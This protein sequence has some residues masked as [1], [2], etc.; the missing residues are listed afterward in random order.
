MRTGPTTSRS[1]LDVPPAVPA[2]GCLRAGP[3]AWR[4]ALPA[5]LLAAVLAACT[6]S[7]AGSEASSDDS[8]GAGGP[9]AAEAAA[10][11][12]A[13]AAQDAAGAVPAGLAGTGLADDV[14]GRS[15]VSTA[16]L[17]VTVD[18]PAT[19]ADRVADLTRAAGGFVAAGSTGGGTG[20][21]QAHLTLRVPAE[22]LEQVLDEVAAL[23]RQVERSTTATDVTAEVADVDSRATSARA[24]LA[25]FRDRLPQAGSVADVLAVEGEIARRQADLDALLAR[26]RVLADRVAL[27]SVEVSLSRAAPATATAQG[28][29]GFTGGLATGWAALLG[30]LRAAAV[31]LGVVLPFAVP[32]AAAA[33]PLVLLHRR[34][35]R[36]ATPP[37]TQ[38]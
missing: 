5:V 9:V 2:A 28:P 29:G 13:A 32:L 30:V 3:A 25:A 1:P 18:D 17:A 37:A 8:A 38:G 10:G 22:R 31:V 4:R 35:P 24:V 14:T 33:V 19:A 6:G 36:T 26:Q 27:A 21:A 20:P 15:V 23:G 34:R 12:E 11:D 16:A 7:G